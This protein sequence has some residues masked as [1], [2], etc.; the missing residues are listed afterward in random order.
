MVVSMKKIGECQYVCGVCG[1][2]SHLTAAEIIPSST[3]VP[4]AWLR[5][6]RSC[7]Q[8]FDELNRSKACRD[9]STCG[10]LGPEYGRF[11][12]CP[13]CNSS[14]VQRRYVEYEVHHASMERLAAR[15]LAEGIIL[16]VLRAYKAFISPILARYVRCR[17][18][19]TCS[20]Y[21]MIAVSKYGWLRGSVKAIRRLRS[22]SP[23]N[24]S[25]CIDFP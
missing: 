19:P 6:C 3:D 25:T 9:C 20:S 12:L 18:Y 22:C 7:W 17:F 13:G 8:D 2:V 14:N 11:S 16:A 1:K 24:C 15:G 10:C 23:R 21:A 4:T 5:S